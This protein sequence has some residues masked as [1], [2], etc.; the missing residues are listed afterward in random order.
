MPS[1]RYRAR[2]SAGGD[3]VDGDS[4]A[5]DGG[6]EGGE[7][8]QRGG[9]RARQVERAVDVRGVA[10]GEAGEDPGCAFAEVVP[11]HPGDGAVGGDDEFEGWVSL[12]D[13]VRGWKPA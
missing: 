6:G 3:K 10:V 1:A 8:S 2:A 7:L 11:G 4:A 5:A 13:K 9:A 12:V